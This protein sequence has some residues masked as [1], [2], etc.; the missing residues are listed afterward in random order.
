M[1]ALYAGFQVGEIKKKK[2]ERERETHN[3]SLLNFFPAS[4]YSSEGK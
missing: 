1:T 4:N 2:R 3:S